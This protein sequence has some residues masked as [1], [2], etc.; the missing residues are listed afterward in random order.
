ML[1]VVKMVVKMVKRVSDG[2]GEGA[3]T[4]MRGSNLTFHCR[5]N[6]Y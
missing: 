3:I 5:R 6:V 2:V 4:A 1:E